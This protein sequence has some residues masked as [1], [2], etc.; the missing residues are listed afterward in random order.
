MRSCGVGTR[1]VKWESPYT[2]TAVKG[3]KL[4][5]HVPR[6]GKTVC[7]SPLKFSLPPT[8]YPFGTP[9]YPPATQ[10]QALRGRV[11]KMFLGINR[12]KVEGV[13]QWLVQKAEASCKERTKVPLGRLGEGESG[14]T[15][16]LACCYRNTFSE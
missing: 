12:R 1:A 4:P 13:Y 3:L 2:G 7:G 14:R 9:P 10:P 5:L 15:A 8:H 16:G 6:C 11:W